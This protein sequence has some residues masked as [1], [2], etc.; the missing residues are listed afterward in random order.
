MSKWI[1]EFGDG[2]AEGAIVIRPVG[3]VGGNE[4]G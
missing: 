1:Y 2:A 4:G 3:G